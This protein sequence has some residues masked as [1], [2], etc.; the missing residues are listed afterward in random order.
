M[1]L[2]Q[3]NRSPILLGAVVAMILVDLILAAWGVCAWYRVYQ[4]RQS[5]RRVQSIAIR[6]VSPSPAGVLPIMLRP[7]DAAEQRSH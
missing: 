3:L 1:S 5:A 7:Q 4:L 2:P 6:R